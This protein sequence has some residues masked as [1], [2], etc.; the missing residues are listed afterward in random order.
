M[1][2][3]LANRLKKLIQGNENFSADQ[4]HLLFFILKFK[5]A[6]QSVLLHKPIDL[7]E[8]YAEALAEIETKL[9]HKQI[10]QAYSYLCRI[11]Y[12]YH[13]RARKSGKLGSSMK[14]D[15]NWAFE[16]N[17]FSFSSDVPRKQFSVEMT[18]P[19]S[20]PRTGDIT[21]VLD[22]IKQRLEVHKLISSKRYSNDSKKAI[23]I[24]KGLATLLS[25]SSG[26]EYGKNF[27]KL[28]NAIVDKYGKRNANRQPY[29]SL[30]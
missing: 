3:N 11:T 9:K 7:P 17:T 29:M 28:A 15:L 25:C 18:S 4:R 8:E 13:Y 24:D 16:G 19:W 26:N 10:K 20:Y 12:R 23:G 5:S 22:R 27:S 6:W 2:S 14:C 1:W 30:R 21:V